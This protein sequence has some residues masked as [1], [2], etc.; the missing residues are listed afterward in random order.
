MPRAY[1]QA[2]PRFSPALEREIGTAGS[3]VMSVTGY[4][5][6]DDWEQTPEL[7]WPASIP[8]YDR[9][10]TDGQASAVL[11]LI[12][13]PARARARWHIGREGAD[14]RVV[15]FVETE[16]GVQ[17]NTQARARRRHEGISWPRYLRE[18]LTTKMW[19][20]HS[21]FEQQ[22]AVGPPLPEQAEAAGANGAR[23][24]PVV[25][26]LRALHPRP[27]RTIT[28]WDISPNGDLNG[29]HQLVAGA[30]GMPE[31][32]LLELDRLVVHVNDMEGS[33]WW[34]RSLFRASYKNWLIKDL[35]IRLG[36][37]VA[38]R[39]GMGIPVV[40]YDP[41]LGGNRA[42]ALALAKAFRA[43]D[44]AG[45]AI[46]PGYTLTLVGVTGNLVDPLPLLKYHD[47][48]IGKN[49]LTMLLDLGHDAGARSLGD[50][51][52]EVATMAENAVL[53]DFAE[54]VTEYVIRD[55]VS[56]NFGED[57]PYP[58]LVV[59]ELQPEQVLTPE[60]LARLAQS[61]VVIPDDE[62]EAALR[63]RWGLPLWPGATE[64]E[65]FDFWP[66]GGMPEVDPED[67]ADP[68]DPAPGDPDPYAPPAP[69]GPAPVGAAHGR[70]SDAIA[71]HLAAVQSRLEARRLARSGPRR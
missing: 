9:M 27:P 51:F 22:Y 20:G 66:D 4:G 52:L 36:P 40:T 50:T 23:I 44:E 69:P 55:L 32:R 64:G 3:G 14:P 2:V 42:T 17:P 43:G 58:P 10:R 71:A 7:R 39:N 57:E 30:N 53:S 54:E 37:Q 34:G 41:E 8:V 46:P 19:A 47:E 1:D 49:A 24:M 26:H 11:R 16:L 13:L 6:V 33:E 31:D 15:R 70:G 59:D 21:V 28:S 60:A 67:P 68:R 63:R 12:V 38:E 25:A 18:A 45:V 65:G 56:L 62:L 61:G 35:L 5:F 29:V 48:S